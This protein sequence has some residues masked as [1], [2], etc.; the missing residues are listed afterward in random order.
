MRPF[1]DSLAFACI[2][3]GVSVMA[4]FAMV[5]QPQPQDNFVAL[6]KCMKLHP[7]RYC[8]LAHAPSTISSTNQK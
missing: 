7:E 3:G 5:Y 6:H 4:A 2:A 8:R 1:A